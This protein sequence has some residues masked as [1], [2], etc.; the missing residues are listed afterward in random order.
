MRGLSNDLR[1]AIRSLAKT[2]GFTAIAIATLVLGIG[3]NTAIFSIVSA[4]LLEPLPYD[5][6]ERL[7]RIHGTNQQTDSA[8]V[9]PLDALDWR[10]QNRSFDRLA[11]VHNSELTVSTG[12]EPVRVG[13]T[14]VTSDFFPLLGVQPRIGRTFLHEEETVGRH[15][16]ALLSHAFWLTSFG[17]DRNVIGRTMRVG[18]APYEIVGVLPPGFRTPLPG[19]HGEPAI[20]RPMAID[21][22]Q[23]GR[24]GHYMQVIARLRAGVTLSQAQQEMI[25]LTE[26]LERKFPDSKM[27]RRA[28]IV[29]LTETIAGDYRKSLTVLMV[30]VAFVLLIACTNV[31]ALFLARAATR[32]REISIRAA[33]GAGRWRLVRQVFAES[34]VVAVAGGA[35]AVAAGAW[36]AAT[37]ARAGATIVP[38]IEETGVDLRILAFTAAAAVASALLFGLLPAVHFA[39]ARPGDALHESGRGVAGAREVRRALR[40]MVVVEVSLS[41]VLLTAAGLLIRS[42][43]TLSSVEPGFDVE[44]IA[45]VPISLSPDRYAEDPKVWG[46]YDEIARR[47]ERHPQIASAAATNILPFSGGFSCDSYLVEGNAEVAAS[48]R[49]CAE[50]R[51]V[52]EGFFETMGI[53]L[54]AGRFFEAADGPDTTPA[55]VISRSLAERIGG[56]PVGRRIRTGQIAADAWGR[57]VGISEDIRHFGLS[58]EPRPELYLLQRQ[59]PYYGMTLVVR[60]RGE[61]AGALPVVR[62][63]LRALDPTLPLNR[64]E[65]MTALVSRS[66]GESR[67][68]VVLFGAFGALALLLATTGIYGIVSHGVANRTRELGVRMALGA[69]GGLVMRSVIGESLRVTLAGVAIGLAGAIAAARLIESLLFGVSPL[70]PITLGASA[71]LLLV[72]ATLATLAPARRATKVDPMEALRA[73]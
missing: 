1:Y 30:A 4:V 59:A 73:E 40:W 52:T 66:L 15:E 22:E 61:V 13:V 19:H 7:V 18:D 72:A 57:I 48:M 60:V 71:I 11:V 53:P 49:P 28:R 21:P 20:Y 38:R 6:P 35:V 63:E 23:T 54:V 33:L 12:A 9:N 32:Q 67:L 25:A 27:G 43:W 41:I 36:L 5:Q 2:P 17:G 29:P 24:G 10:A 62:R 64:L 51:S 34:L 31:G 50:V 58:E 16:V 56:D 44:R 39:K 68:R 8:N 69:D 26:D 55:V 37:I 14:R 46:F 47:L 70:D 45:F 65:P 3:A 42:L